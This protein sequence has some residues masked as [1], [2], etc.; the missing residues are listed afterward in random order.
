MLVANAT[1]A[2]IPSGFMSSLCGAAGEKT[3]SDRN[4]PIK[5]QEWQQDCERCTIE[6][7]VTCNLWLQWRKCGLCFTM[8]YPV[9]LGVGEIHSTLAL[10]CGEPDRPYSCDRHPA[11]RAGLSAATCGPR[12]R[13]L[14]RAGAR[15]VRASVAGRAQFPQPGR[16]EHGPG[17]RRLPLVRFP[18]RTRPLGRLPD[19]QLLFRRQRSVFAAWRLHPDP[20]RGRTRPAVGGDQHRRPGPV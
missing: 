6:S 8:H 17:R 4:H 9:H 12:R 1:F 5:V 19:A 10:I 14:A 2:L 13:S 3:K 7:R 16:D 20:A 11:C 15:G 18:G